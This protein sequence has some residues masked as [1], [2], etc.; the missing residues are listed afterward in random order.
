MIN[1]P[2]PEITLHKIIYK[3]HKDIQTSTN[4]TVPSGKPHVKTPVS[5]SPTITLTVILTNIKK[6]IPTLKYPSTKSS[7]KK[8]DTVK[9]K[10]M[11]ILKISFK[12]ESKPIELVKNK[13]KPTQII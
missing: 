7:I 1:L 11:M 13:N 6:Y 2:I 8:E 3:H 10:L 4:S 5:I 12:K 9:E